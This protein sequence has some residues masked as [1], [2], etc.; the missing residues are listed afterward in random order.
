MW[1][2]FGANTL[3]G[4]TSGSRADNSGHFHRGEK[5]PLY[6][7][8]HGTH[9]RFIFRNFEMFINK[10][11]HT[12]F[13]VFVI[14]LNSDFEFI[15]LPRRRESIRGNFFLRLSYLTLISSSDMYLRNSQVWSFY[16][17]FVFWVPYYVVIFNNWSYISWFHFGVLFWPIN[18]TETLIDIEI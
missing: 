9:F 10:N 11:K 18:N 7:H 5:S 17:V 13:F 6:R 12:L 15:L 2:Y 8:A 14:L 16:F 3:Y 4:Q 1:T